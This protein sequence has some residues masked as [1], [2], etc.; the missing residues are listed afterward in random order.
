M[1]YIASN[2][3][4]NS[5]IH[6]RPEKKINELN[7]AKTSK[8]KEYPKQITEDVMVEKE[9]SRKEPPEPSTVTTC[10]LLRPC[11]DGHDKRKP[12]TDHTQDLTLNMSLC[13][14]RHVPRHVPLLLLL[15]LFSKRLTEFTPLYKTCL[16]VILVAGAQIDFIE[17]LLPL[18][19]SLA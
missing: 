15:L 16:H 2:V 10:A 5:K 6:L 1:I 4:R 17:I 8:N 13:V 7:D 3:H 19:S 14:S 11:S 9:E 18:R 12:R